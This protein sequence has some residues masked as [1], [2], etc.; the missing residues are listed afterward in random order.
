MSASNILL[1]LE[2][3]SW[4]VEL[5]YIVYKLNFCME[6]KFLPLFSFC[7]SYGFKRGRWLTVKDMFG[8]NVLNEVRLMSMDLKRR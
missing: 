5:S 1:T 7:V 8:N 4:L 2:S 3:L 6:F